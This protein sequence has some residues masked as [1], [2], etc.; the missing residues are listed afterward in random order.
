MSKKYLSALILLGVLTIS[1]APFVASA[2]GGT[3]INPP[4]PNGLNV[5]GIMQ[6]VFT[7]IWQLF[8]GI[9]VIM[10]VVAGILFVTSSG[11]PGKLATARNSV[12]WGVVG[13][14]VAVIAFS[15]V[16]VVSGWV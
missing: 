12:I 4:T 15:I 1:V 5:A 11:D 14:V 6:Q 3:S 7:P 9:A 13:I 16:G 8:V 2:A 10:F